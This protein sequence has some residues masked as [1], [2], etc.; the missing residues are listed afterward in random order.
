M[1]TRP[2]LLLV[3][4][5]AVL[6]TLVVLAPTARAQGGIAIPDPIVSIEV[7]GTPATWLISPDGTGPRL[8]AIGVSV[9]VQI[10]DNA[11]FPIAG[12]PFQDVWLDD[13]G[14]GAISLCQGG[15]VADANTNVDGITTFSSSMSGGG[16]TED[17]LWVYIA[18]IPYA[19]PID[20]TVV[21]PDIDGDLG[22]GLPDVSLFADDY[23]NGYQVRTDFAPNG[24]LDLADVGAFALHLGAQ[25]P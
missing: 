14:S 4:T 8:D 19:G 13:G 6:L 9:T 1:T 21:S 7:E 16:W 5:A 3:S 20:L 2:S 12:Y 22:V 24:I 17:G 11:G 15:S 10:L 18:G 23:V 25:C